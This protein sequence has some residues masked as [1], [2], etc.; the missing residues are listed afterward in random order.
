MADKVWNLP[1]GVY[2]ALATPMRDGKIDREAWPRLVQ[3]Q[4]EAGVAGLVPLGSTGEAAT[5]LADEKEWLVRSCVEMARG[6]AAVVAGAGSNST[7]AAVDNVRAVKAWGADAA[8]VV[9]PYYNKPQQH[10]LVSHYLA[11]VSRCD[12]P[13]VMYNVPGRTAV[14]LLPATAA[15]LAAEPQ[16]V[17]LKESSGDL[18]QIEQAIAAC[19]LKVLSGDDGLNFAVYGLGGRGCV[20]VV[21]NLLPGHV[22]AVWRAWAAGDVGRAF[23]LSRALDPVTRACFIETNPVPVK[24]LLHLA[25][26]CAPEVRLPLG[27]VTGAHAADLARFYRDV[28]A[29]LLA[30][31]REVAA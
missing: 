10:G 31:D 18:G 6:R 12:L 30:S 15:A 16:I 8:L 27:E 11:L 23:W 13:I 1:E 3:R 2:T 14:N 17:G 28:L 19:N 20:S 25:G 4:L 7:A 22:V 26:L 24:N 5:L 9:T 29:G 21:S